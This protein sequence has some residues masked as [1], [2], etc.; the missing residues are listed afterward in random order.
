M[1]L[2]PF[3]GACAGLQLE[4]RPPEGFDLTGTWRLVEDASDTPP[5]HRRLRARGGMLAFVTQD[6]P[7]LRATE[8]RIQQSPDSMGIRYDGR[9]YRDVSWGERRR[10]LWEVRAGWHEGDLYILSDA[11]DADAREI[12]RLSDEGRR[13]DVDVRVE[14]GGEDVELTRVFRRQPSL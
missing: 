12:L 14:S 11:A 3:L 9:H 13:L 4:Q 6:F 1:L 2:L 10:G 8:M 5:T 7:V